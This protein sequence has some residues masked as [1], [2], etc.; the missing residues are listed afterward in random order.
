MFQSSRRLLI[1]VRSSSHNDSFCRLLRL[2]W[3][4]QRV[5]EIVAIHICII[6]RKVPYY[7]TDRQCINWSD[8]VMCGVEIASN[9]ELL[10]FNGVIRYRSPTD[11]CIFYITD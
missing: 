11:F 10:H 2:T 3:T 1:L 5:C 4:A 6:V 8:R 9:T 7:R